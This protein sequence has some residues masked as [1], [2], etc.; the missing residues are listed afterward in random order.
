MIGD[1]WCRPEC[2]I[3]EYDEYNENNELDEYYVPPNPCFLNALTK[4][5]SNPDECKSACDNEEGCTGYA[6]SDSSYTYPNK[7]YIYGN[8]SSKNQ[9]ATSSWT[10]KPHSFIEIHSSSG[11]NSNNPSH[12]SIKCWKNTK[13]KDK[14]QGNNTLGLQIYLNISILTS[15]F[16]DKLNLKSD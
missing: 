5:S 1:G 7:C 3:P 2:K 13:E 16:V 6:I 10:A 9:G 15:V 11:F 8:F 14:I 4:D 12:K